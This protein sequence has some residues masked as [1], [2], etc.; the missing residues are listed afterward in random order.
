LAVDFYQTARY[1]VAE[2]FLNFGQCVTGSAWRIHLSQATKEQLDKGGR[3]QLEYRGEIDVKGK[4]KM[5]TYW[6][7][8]KAGF[9]KQLPTP[10]PIE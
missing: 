9:E 6:L 8:G 4:G 2:E 7:L 5:H 10:P 1:L 3:F